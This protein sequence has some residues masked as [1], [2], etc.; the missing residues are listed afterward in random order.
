MTREIR[1]QRNRA[2]AGVG[3]SSSM[4]AGACDALLFAW[5]AAYY[6]VVAFGAA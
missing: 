1:D 5:V 6:V 2:C 3:V 4:I